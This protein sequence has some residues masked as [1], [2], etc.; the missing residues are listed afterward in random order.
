MH[1]KKGNKSCVLCSK[2]NK[3]ASLFFSST[4]VLLTIIPWKMTA[5]ETEQTLSIGVN[6]CVFNYSECIDDANN[7][8]DYK[9]F[10]RQKNR[11]KVD[12]KVEKKGK[13]LTKKDKKKTKRKKMKMEIRQKKRLLKETKKGQKRRGKWKKR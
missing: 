13:K 5:K 3:I 6:L 7:T 10:Q 8:L 2:K 12:K 11:K 1:C 9:Y 4:L